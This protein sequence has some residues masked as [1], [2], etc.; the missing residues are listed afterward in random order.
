MRLLSSSPWGKQKRLLG[1]CEKCYAQGM[2]MPKCDQQKEKQAAA[3]KEEYGVMRTSHLLI[4]PL[5]LQQN[6][7]K[8]LSLDLVPSNLTIRYFCFL[9]LFLIYMRI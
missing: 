9:E 8:D 7:Y 2:T 6:T 5:H 3:K 1:G 4:H